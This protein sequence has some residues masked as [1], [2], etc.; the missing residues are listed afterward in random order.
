MIKLEVNIHTA[1]TLKKITTFGPK[2]LVKLYIYVNIDGMRLL[3]IPD[4]VTET[5][6]WRSLHHVKTRDSFHDIA[7]KYI[8]SQ[9]TELV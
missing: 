7:S 2:N 3:K 9:M 5:F 1:L 4:T 8:F 6:V